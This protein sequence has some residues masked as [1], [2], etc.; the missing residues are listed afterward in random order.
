MLMIGLRGRS[1]VELTLLA[2]RSFTPSGRGGAGA[3]DRDGFSRGGGAIAGFQTGGEGHLGLAWTWILWG[4]LLVLL[5]VFHLGDFL[6]VRSV[7]VGSRSRE[8]C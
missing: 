7:G 2:L 4:L 1:P 8:R 6:G 5:L 3:A